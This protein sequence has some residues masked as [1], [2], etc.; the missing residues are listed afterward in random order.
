MRPCP[1]S[2]RAPPRPEFAFRPQGI[3]LR[4]QEWLAQYRLSLARI[5][6]FLARDREYIAVFFQCVFV[7]VHPV[8]AFVVTEED[9]QVLNAVGLTTRQEKSVLFQERIVTSSNDVLCVRR[10]VWADVSCK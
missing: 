9:L 8:C 1:R 3:C 5:W 6:P 7:F 2:S 4:H 10:Q